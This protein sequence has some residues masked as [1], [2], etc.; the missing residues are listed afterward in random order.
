MAVSKKGLG[1]NVSDAAKQRIEYI[2]DNFP[3]VYLSFSGGKDST[4]MLHMVAEEARKRSRKFGLLFIDLEAQYEHT[5]NHVRSMFKMYADCTI[6]YWIAKPLILR[7]AVSVFEPRWKCWDEEARDRWVRDYP[8][9]AYKG[10]L[11]F[12]QHGME[13][14]EFTELFGH[15][16]ADDTP[17]AAF[18]GIRADESLN[19][20]RTIA[21]DGSGIEGKPWTT[22][23]RHGLFNAY[24]IYDWRTED[25][26]RYHAKTKLPYNHLY[27][28][29][30]LAG[31]SIHQMRI[32]QPYGDDQRKGLHLYQ[33]LEPDTWGKVVARVAGVNSG[34]L[35]AQ[36]SG[37]INGTIKV[38]KPDGH[39]WQS[40]A[41]ML[42]DTM[43]QELSGHYRDKIFVFTQWWAKNGYPT[44]PDEAD[45]KLENSKKVPSWRRICKTL[46][47][48]DYWCKGLSFTATKASNYLAYRDLM[49]RKRGGISPRGKGISK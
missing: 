46:L 28:L 4:V 39:T 16:Y 11:P 12:F 44:I 8:D 25:V 23:K 24:P 48:N 1:I 32:C 41:E 42:L 18:V 37:N 43:P 20:Y 29:M 26:W 6:P 38:H 7:N 13:F 35:Y 22:W 36:E 34:A 5:I 45:P 47:R 27:D 31:L 2:F 33:V 49:R 10:D 9:Q 40:F 14:E 15:W 19:R 3:K 21:S 30:H 17:T